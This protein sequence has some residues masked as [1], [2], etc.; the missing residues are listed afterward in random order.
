MLFLWL[1]G[2]AVLLRNIVYLLGL[3]KNNKDI[4]D[5]AQSLAP[6]LHNP[7]EELKKQA[8]KEETT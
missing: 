2:I 7:T 1:A 6:E 4:S 8:L 5:H 3:K